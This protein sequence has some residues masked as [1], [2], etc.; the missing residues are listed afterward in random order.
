MDKAIV[1]ITSLMSEKC[2]EIFKDCD[3][4]NL[5]EILIRV[6][7]PVMLYYAGHTHCMKG[8]TFSG[9]EIEEMVYNFC[10]NSV[11]AYTDSIRDGFITLPG[12]HRAGIA[13]RAVYRDKKLSNIASF[14]GVNIRIAKEHIGCAE[15]LLPFIYKEEKIKN[16][17][18]I[19][20][21][22]GGKTTILRDIARLLGSRHRVTIVDERSEIAAMNN[23]K[24]QFD[25]GASTDV[26]DAFLKTDGIVHA[27]RSLSPEVIITDEIGTQ[28]DI[29]A[30]KNILK[31]GSKIITSIH[32]ESFYEIRRKKE[33]LLSFF[34][35]AVVMKKCE[36]EECI[37]LWEQ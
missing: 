17:L 26:L 36:V 19:S 1:E 37:N 25:I 23:G 21:P 29:L 32:G 6:N 28:E 2:A 22:S 4:E 8:M 35:V 10:R 34:D 16:T 7:R 9:V 30:I 11:Y 5:Q 13:G 14:S 20:P 15:K 31:S 18:I 33:E 3:T 12:G 27:L 24:P